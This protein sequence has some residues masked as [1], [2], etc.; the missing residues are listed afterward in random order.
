[1]K[2]IRRSQVFSREQLLSKRE[3]ENE[4][5][6]ENKLLAYIRSL[7]DEMINE[8]RYFLCGKTKQIIESEMEKKRRKWY[9]KMIC[10]RD[11]YCFS[12]FVFEIIKKIDKK[13]LIRLILEGTLKKHTK[14]IK[15]FRIYREDAEGQELIEKWKKGEIQEKYDNLIKFTISG[16]IRSFIQPSYKEVDKLEIEELNEYVYLYKSLL[17]VAKKTAK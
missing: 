8:I 13:H 3:N 17:Y 14:L 7:P 5:N 15:E 2:V 6:N 10:R 11:S 4:I 16:E 9:R 1:M 12:C